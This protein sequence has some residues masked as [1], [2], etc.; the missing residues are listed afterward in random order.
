MNCPACG[1]Y[2][3]IGAQTCFHC[4]LALPTP[5][6]GDARCA[7]HPELQ[8]TGA[9]SRCGTFGCAQCLTQK[10]EQWLCP[11][12]L[13]REARLPWDDRQ[14]IGAVKAWW[15]TSLR[16]LGSPI[17][18]L[19]N[20]HRVDT[21][22]GSLLFILF[23]TFAANITGGL[24]GGRSFFGEVT[25]DALVDGVLGVASMTLFWFAQSLGVQFVLLPISHV[26]LRLTGTTRSFATTCRAH[27]LALA[28]DIVGLIPMC[29][30]FIALFWSAGLRVLALKELHGVSTGRAVIAV[31]APLGLLGGAVLILIM[32]AGR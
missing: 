2:N 23:S 32:L 16:M 20:A 9:C 3:P 22:G 7:A 4:S 21:V 8:A 12:C 31:L 18:T 24:L 27:A 13:A 19:A 1:Y 6:A 28:P 17:E 25:R 11:A 29:G 26:A 14:E 10:Q 5:A 15:R 30:G